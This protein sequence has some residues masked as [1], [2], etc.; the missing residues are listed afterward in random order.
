MVGSS[1][2]LYLLQVANAAFPTGA[3]N[4]SY[5]LETWIDASQVNDAATAEAACRDW[6]RYGSAPADGAAVAAAHRAA[7]AGDQEAIVR[8]DRI[9]GALKLARETR[10]ASLKTGRATIN[11]IRDVFQAPRILAYEALV[12]EG[13]CGGHQAVA[14]G[15]AAVDF[16]VSQ[17]QA[18]LAF[19]QS[20]LMNIV[21]V[22]ARLIPLGQV[23]AQ[24]I[25]ARAWPLLQGCAAIAQ[26]RDLRHFGSATAA[27]DI[28]AM[29]HERLTT[30]LCMS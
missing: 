15:I 30:R 27:L 16:E 13:R 7:L 26:S 12:R 22:A 5:G 17:E 28:A 21:G 18:V 2:L 19:L 25:V 4:H 23:D 20:G 11:A 9:V 6:L 10:E 3:F 24:R 14:F 1:P 8:V 29:R